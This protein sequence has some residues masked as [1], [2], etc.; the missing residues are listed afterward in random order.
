MSESVSENKQ[1]ATDKFTE[2]VENQAAKAQKWELDD[3]D[4]L[5][6]LAGEAMG[7]AITIEYIVHDWSE[8]YKEDY[9][10]D[11]PATRLKDHAIKFNLQPEQS[12]NSHPRLQEVTA[13]TEFSVDLDNCIE[14]KIKGR[15]QTKTDSMD[16]SILINRLT[17]LQ[18]EEHLKPVVSADT[19]VLE[20]ADNPL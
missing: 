18:E 5:G 19:P 4:R 13:P 11:L 7:S 17:T 2:F 14:F 1:R 20:R 16:V 12:E 3:G 8:I 9:D 6:F 10:K 15:L